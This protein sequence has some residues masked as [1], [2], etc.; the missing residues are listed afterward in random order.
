VEVKEQVKANDVKLETAIEAKL[1]EG[2]E[3]KF[4]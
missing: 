1:L 3:E 4:T 2:F